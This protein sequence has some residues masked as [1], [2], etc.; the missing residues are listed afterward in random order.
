MKRVYLIGSLRNRKIVEVGNALR[1]A[2]HEAVD[3]WMAPGPEADDHW[4]TYE[5]NRGR[6]YAEALKGLAATHAFEFDLAHIKRVD[7][8][9]LV[10]PCGK[11]GHLELGYMIGRGQLGYVLF[12]EEP[13][14]DRWDLMYKFAHGIFFNVDDLIKALQ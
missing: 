4:K 1:E 10:L 13:A 8:G 2:G 14:K 9:V 7:A 3:D 5:S 11:S 12:P 6:T